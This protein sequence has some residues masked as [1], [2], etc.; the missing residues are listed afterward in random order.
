ML[1]LHFWCLCYTRASSSLQTLYLESN[2]CTCSRESAGVVHCT[3]CR[4]FWSLCRMSS[5]LE[6][7]LLFDKFF[8]LV[9]GVVCSRELAKRTDEK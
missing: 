4:G 2:L 1:E 7:N 9:L 5:G 6:K 8:L 3:A